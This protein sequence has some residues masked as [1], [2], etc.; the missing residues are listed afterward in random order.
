MCRVNHN[1]LD[2]LGEASERLDPSFRNDIGT[3]RRNGVV[4][5]EYLPRLG[6][7]YEARCQM[8]TTPLEITRKLG[9]HGSMNA[10]TRLREPTR[11]APLK[12]RG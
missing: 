4:R 3:A 12:R 1:D 2:G 7:S 11:E 10:D 9:S 6:T 8:H 5:R